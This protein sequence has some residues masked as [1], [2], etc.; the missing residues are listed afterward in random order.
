LR[1]MVERPDA[2]LSEVE[3]ILKEADRQRR[4][5]RERKYEEARLRKFSQA[6]RRPVTAGRSGQ[7]AAETEEGE[8]K[9]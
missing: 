7:V 6:R 8:A 9:R 1:V 2:T 5:A 4:L 3:E